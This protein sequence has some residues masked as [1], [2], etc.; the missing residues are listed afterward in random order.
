LVPVLI[1]GLIA[2][3]SVWIVALLFPA[4]A[5]SLLESKVISNSK[6]ALVLLLLIPFAPP[7]VSSFALGTLV[8]PAVPGPN[9]ATEIMSTFED[10]QQYDKKWLLIT[11][12]AMLGGFN[13][14]LMFW[15]VAVG[16]GN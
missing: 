10:R 1:C 15:V 8:F 13:C 6:L 16:A 11:S 14:L 2:T 4:F 3:A 12:S 5:F 7:F 9:T